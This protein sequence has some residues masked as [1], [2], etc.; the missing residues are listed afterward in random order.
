MRI[1]HVIK[2]HYNHI[3]IIHWIF[4]LVLNSILHELKKFLKTKQ[5]LY[6]NIKIEKYDRLNKKNNISFKNKNILFQMYLK[7]HKEIQ[8]RRIPS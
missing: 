5:G 6:K 4:H 2:V 3:Y 8:L 7:F 1:L